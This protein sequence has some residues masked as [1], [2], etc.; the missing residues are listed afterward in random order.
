MPYDIKCLDLA[1]V[2]L[3]DVPDID[4]PAN[5]DELAQLIQTTVEDWISYQEGPCELC[6]EARG[7]RHHT[8]AEVI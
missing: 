4:N 5:R 2:F 3:S 7:K 1:A 8:H 6:G